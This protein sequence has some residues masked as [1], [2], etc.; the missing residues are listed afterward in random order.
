MEIFWKMLL[1]MALSAVKFV[2]GF[3]SALSSGFSLI[4]V[5]IGTVGGGMV[6]VII[7]LYLW[8]LIVHVF[9][10][11]VPKKNKPVKF[12]KT[13]RIIVKIIKEYELYGVAFLTPLVLTMPIGS[14]IATTIEPNKWRIKLFMFVSL[15]FWT[16]LLYGLKV[17]FNFD[18]PGLLHF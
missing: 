4:E 16:L 13:K 7:Y 2:I 6:G 5:L 14:I 3:G 18:L 1:V 9:R 15:L 8:D 10:K 11:F 12:S 17:L